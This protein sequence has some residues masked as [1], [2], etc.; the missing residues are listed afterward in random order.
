MKKFLSFLMAAALFISLAAVPAYAQNYFDVLKGTPVI[1]GQIDDMYLESVCVSPDTNQN[2]NIN[3]AG[4]GQGATNTVD[5]CYTYYIWDDSCLYIAS[6]VYDKTINQFSYDECY[7]A[8]EGMAQQ[9]DLFVGCFIAPSGDYLKVS[10]DAFATFIDG[11]EEARS[12]F[13]LDN[14]TYASTVNTDEGYYIVE[15]AL[16]IADGAEEGTQLLFHVMI[17]NSGKKIEKGGFYSSFGSCYAGD[18]LV[19]SGD[20][21]SDGYDPSAVTTASTAKP[22][23]TVETVD[24]E[25]KEEATE[26]ENTEEST[27]ETEEITVEESTAEETEKESTEPEETEKATD[28]TS[29]SKNDDTSSAN[30]DNNSSN[31]NNTV[32]MI[33]IIAAAVIA[34]IIILVVVLKKKT[35]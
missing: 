11:N 17:S 34:V 10:V 3:H 13:N 20:T 24:A 27:G 29:E 23:T 7:V 21:V 15:M 12:F 31:S 16:P 32:L 9:G 19:F 22:E 35:A 33:V 18:T 26:P 8:D 2:I 30:K 25:T 4:W 28:A 6:M 1:D 5:T 14:A